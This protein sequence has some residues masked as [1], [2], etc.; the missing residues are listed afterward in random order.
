MVW[1]YMCLGG[2]SMRVL[3]AAV[4]LVPIMPKDVNRKP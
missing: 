2:L 3:V 4:G 1:D